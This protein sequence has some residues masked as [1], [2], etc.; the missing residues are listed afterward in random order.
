MKWR[1]GRA[2]VPRC[3]YCTP[4]SRIRTPRHPAAGSHR[5][6][7]A[8]ATQSA[9]AAA[10]H[11]RTC[12]AWPRLTWFSGSGH[13]VPAARSTS[14]S[15]RT[16]STLKAPCR[17]R[18]PCARAMP[19]SCPASAPRS[20]GCH[21]SCHPQPLPPQRGCAQRQQHEINGSNP[22]RKST[23]NSVVDCAGVA[24]RPQRG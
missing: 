2:R 11:P 14:Q 9:S 12:C 23:S 19:R 1:T 21:R 7:S 5:C 16:R 8:R 13:T 17:P 4:S 6:G 24:E 10:I 18:R 15:A 22:H 20:S 3:H